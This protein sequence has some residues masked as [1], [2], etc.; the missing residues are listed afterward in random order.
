MPMAHS[1][2]KRSATARAAH[3]PRPKASPKLDSPELYLNPHL[4]LLAFQRR[5]L[6]EARDRA[7]PLLERVKFLSILASN[8]DEFFMVRVAGLWQQIEN[9]SI[10]THIDGR[11]ARRATGIDSPGSDFAHHEMYRVWR[12][13]LAPELR[14]AGI[15]I[16][17]PG[18]LN[19]QQ[20]TFLDDYFRREVYPVS[21]TAR[22][23]SRPALSAYFE[24]ESEHWRG[25]QQWRRSGTFCPR[26]SSGHAAAASA[27]SF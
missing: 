8:I 27:A 18:E 14:G 16:L 10:E 17:E 5:V 13:E 7:T 15:N 22:R 3:V 4:S 12:E 11:S 23:R 1:A 2:R 20:Q 24:F 26:Q 19:P 9:R 25:R 6:E 21:D